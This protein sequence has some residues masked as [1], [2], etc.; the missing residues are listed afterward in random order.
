[1]GKGQRGCQEKIILSQLLMITRQRSSCMYIHLLCKCR[2]GH[3][4]LR[5]VLSTSVR[6]IIFVRLVYK[7]KLL[8]NC[9]ANLLK[10]GNLRLLLG[11]LLGEAQKD[12]LGGEEE[13]R[14]S[15]SEQNEPLLEESLEAH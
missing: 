13:G 4:Q 14:E 12:S 6:I 11:S 15:A 9:H 8:R 3:F 7:I 5:L 10:R 2:R 1:M